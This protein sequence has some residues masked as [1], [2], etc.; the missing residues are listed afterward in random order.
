MYFESIGIKYIQM[1]KSL[2][3]ALDGANK[4]CME[5]AFI[6]F[7]KLISTMDRKMDHEKLIFI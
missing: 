4:F 2:I 6:V 3:E 5:L 1:C 7:F